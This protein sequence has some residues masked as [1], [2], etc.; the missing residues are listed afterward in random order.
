MKI[1]KRNLTEIILHENFSPICGVVLGLFFAVVMITGMVLA[2]EVEEVRQVV[3]A[4]PLEGMAKKVTI[5][6][7]V[8]GDTLDVQITLEIRVR[9]LDCWAP[10]TR[11]RDLDEKARGMASKQYLQGLVED[12]SAV[13][14]V[15][16]ESN[17]ISDVFTFGRVLG[18]V[19]TE[20]VNLSEEMV[21]AG[22]ATVEKVEE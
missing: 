2:G 19:W 13:L 15:P 16:W 17:K 20:G 6:R 1:T 12:G 9:L 14:Y 5:V 4:K 11:T 7:V 18:H 21:R 10:E 3:P 22:H 8:D